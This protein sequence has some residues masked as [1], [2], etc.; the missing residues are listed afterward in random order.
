[1]DLNT[2]EKTLA[3]FR[4][5]GGHDR[6][7]LQGG[8]PTLHPNLPSII[9]LGRQLGY[10]VNITT[11]GSFDNSFW[12]TIS[13]DQLVSISFSID[14]WQSA[15]HCD[16]RRVSEHYF[17]RLIDNIRT[18]KQL[19]YHTRAICTVARENWETAIGLIRFLADLHVDVLAYHALGRTGNSIGNLTPLSQT[20]WVEFCQQIENHEPLD[21][22]TVYYPP[23]YVSPDDL[24]KFHY[25]GYPT[26]PAR[27]FDRP[28]VYPDGTVYACPIFMDETPNYVILGNDR[29]NRYLRDGKVMNTLFSVE[30][31]CAGCG[32]SRTC[33]GGC[34][35]YSTLNSYSDHNRCDKN[36]I[37]LCPLWTT[38]AW[39]KP[40]EGDLHEF[41]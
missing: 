21:E 15:V 41:R 24:E 23:T 7:F 39:G 5:F 18:A 30:P 16:I 14:S 25:R 11:N 2:I 8:E 35:A 22:L 12:D 28:H 34:P 13:H 20:E 40:A 37:P 33:G 31:E 1:M 26:C 29:F 9:Q 6:L 19:G 3:Y 10:R 38:F 27:T 36:L 17:F 32:M 4:V